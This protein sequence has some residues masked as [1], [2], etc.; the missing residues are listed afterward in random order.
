MASKQKYKWHEKTI[1]SY[2]CEVDT[3]KIV[4]QYSRMGLSDGVYHA[5]VNGDNLGEYISEKC[6]KQA[7]EKQIE[8]NEQDNLEYQKWVVK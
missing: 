7:I 6:A 3:G 2:Y 4:G 8:K 1:S 5:Q